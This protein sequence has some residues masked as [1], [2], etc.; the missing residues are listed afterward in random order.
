MKSLRSVQ[1]PDSVTIQSWIRSPPL[2]SSRLQTCSV[3]AL[4]FLT[5][6]F[7]E[8]SDCL[9][10]HPVQRLTIQD[11]LPRCPAQHSGVRAAQPVSILP[12]HV[13]LAK[14]QSIFYL[15]F[16]QFH[17]VSCTQ[18]IRCIAP[19]K[20]LEFCRFIW[21]SFASI[22]HVHMNWFHLWNFAG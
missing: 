18:Y 5:V 11:Y 4:G 9:S 15:C 19:L 21:N 12:F 8:P 1:R 14:H 16:S 2:P 6:Q 10:H 3:H 17:W 7:K 13:L 22:L 20:H